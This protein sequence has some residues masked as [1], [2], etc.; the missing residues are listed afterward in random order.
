[1]LKSK[2]VN[3]DFEK[4]SKLYEI[5]PVAFEKE[6]KRIIE[7]EIASYPPEIQ[8]R[9]KKYQWVLDMKRKRCKNPLEACFM[10]YDMLMDQVY[11]ENGLLENLMHLLEAA[12]HLKKRGKLPASHFENPLGKEQKVKTKIL[13]FKKGQKDPHPLAKRARV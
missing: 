4:L 10:F 9:L 1:M 2:N 8:E 7:E 13:S 3:L 5:D 6:R 12:N 11:G